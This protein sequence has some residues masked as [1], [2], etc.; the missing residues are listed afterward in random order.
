MAKGNRNSIYKVFSEKGPE[1]VPGKFCCLVCEDR[2]SCNEL[3]DFSCMYCHECNWY[4]YSKTNEKGYCEFKIV[5]PEIIRGMRKGKPMHRFV[6][7]IR[8]W[9]VND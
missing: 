7:W 9:T 3:G 5:F 4:R 6:E 2:S 1:I 8:G